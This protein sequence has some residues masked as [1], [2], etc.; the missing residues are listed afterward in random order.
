MQNASSYEKSIR[1]Q[2]HEES[3]CEC[4]KLIEEEERSVVMMMMM[5]MT[6]VVVVSM[7][8]LGFQ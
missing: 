5:M 3:E 7:S 1:R 6:M 8:T 4:A 2:W